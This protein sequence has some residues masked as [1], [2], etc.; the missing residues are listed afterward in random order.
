MVTWS[1]SKKELSLPVPLLSV[2]VSVSVSAWM[3]SLDP[4]LLKQFSAESLSAMLRQL[5]G[6]KDLVLEGRIMRCLAKIAGMEVLRGSGV[7]RVFRLE[8]MAPGSKKATEAT[9]PT[10]VFILQVSGWVMFGLRRPVPPN[11]SCCFSSP[12][13]P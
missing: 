9:A 5:A 13:P 4:S 12:R 2:S 6:D 1:N 10:R 11:T 7:R 3:A 8:Q